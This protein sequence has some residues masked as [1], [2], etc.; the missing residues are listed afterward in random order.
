[1]RLHPAVV[2]PLMLLAFTPSQAEAISL[3]KQCRLSCG[4]AIDTCVSAG[5]RRRR[6]KRQVLKQ[7][8]REG[9]ATCIETTTTTLTGG[10]TTTIMPGQSVNDCTLASAVDRR[11]PGADRIV[12]FTF[13]AYTPPCIRI[14]AGQSITF[15]GSFVNHPLVGGT[16][17]SVKTPDPSSPIPSTSSGSMLVVPFPSAG[18]FPF[19]CDVHA[20]GFGM[21][22][23]VF[24]EP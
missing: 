8:R 4:A 24:V 3:R 5:G 23:A 20:L 17:T 14:A 11:D 6:C 21:F 7:C 1:M 16:V 15:S 22:G 9:L 18:T 13:T 10:T 12:T 2:L 19:Y